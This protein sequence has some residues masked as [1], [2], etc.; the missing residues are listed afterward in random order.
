MLKTLQLHSKLLV[1]LLGA[2]LTV[3][4]QFYGN[5]ATVQIVVSVLTALG[6]YSIPNKAVK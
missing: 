1:A 3:A 5:N 6:V 4:V 2:V